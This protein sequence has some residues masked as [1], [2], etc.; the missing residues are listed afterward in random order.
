MLLVAL[1]GGGGHNLDLQPPQVC[2][3]P[4][5]T[6]ATQAATQREYMKRPNQLTSARAPSEMVKSGSSPQARVTVPHNRSRRACAPTPNVASATSDK[7]SDSG[8][9]SVTRKHLSCTVHGVAAAYR[10]NGA[11]SGCRCL[12]GEATLTCRANES[13]SSEAPV[14]LSIPNVKCRRCKS[15]GSICPRWQARRYSSCNGQVNTSHT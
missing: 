15:D 8:T 2:A 12:S 11:A 10:H 5:A 1:Q 9:P 4:P 13:C 14:M 6:A 7:L 3:T